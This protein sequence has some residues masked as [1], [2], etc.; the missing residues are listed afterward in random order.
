MPPSPRETVVI[1]GASAGVG[2]ALARE[3]ARGGANVALLARGSPGLEA[4]AREIEALG[5]F[6]ESLRVELM[7][8]EI[9]IHV[10]M[11]QLPAVNT[12]AS[13]RHAHHRRRVVDPAR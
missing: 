5:A 11:V 3:F 7:H 6:T 4:A 9:D 12:V 1:T 13:R 10:T 8:D 2:R